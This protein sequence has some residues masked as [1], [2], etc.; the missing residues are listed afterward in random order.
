[1]NITGALITDMPRL[2]PDQGWAL[3]VGT[4]AKHH[5]LRAAVVTRRVVAHK[6]N[7][8]TLYNFMSKEVPRYLWG[9]NRRG[10]QGHR[11]RVEQEFRS[12]CST[13]HAV[14]GELPNRGVQ[15][16]L[17]TDTCVCGTRHS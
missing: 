10:I 1:M 2:H 16:D 4:G 9:A 8:A 12:I 7:V 15:A 6:D 17:S 11:P 14:P 3:V 5:S 13:V